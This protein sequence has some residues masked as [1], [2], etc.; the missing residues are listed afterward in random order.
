VSGL[1]ARYI[2]R[3]ENFGPRAGSQALKIVLVVEAFNS[4]GGAIELVD[5]LSAHLAGRGHRVLIAST[6]AA[7]DNERPVPAGVECVYL[8]IRGRKPLSW[9]H[10]ERLWREPRLPRRSELAALIAR[11]QPDLVSGHTCHWDT[12]PTLASICRATRVPWVHNLYDWRDQGRRAF[13]NLPALKSAAGLIAIS[14]ASKDAFSSRFAPAA[15]AEVIIGGVDENTATPYPAPRPYLFCA[16]RMDLRNK[17]LDTLIAAFNQVAQG[18]DS[19]DLLIAGSGP[20]REEVA[21]MAAASPRAERIR[22]LGRVSREQLLALHAGARLFV[23]PSR[24]AEGL[25]IV[26]LE[27][28]M[29]G[30]AVIGTRTGGV[31]EIISDGDNGR[32]VAEDD[33]SALAG[34]IE[35]LL[36]D[37]AG[38]RAMGERG[39]ERARQYTWARL[40][41]RHE[42]IYQACLRRRQ[43]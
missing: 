11:W 34:A 38:T 41:Q 15:G 31:E 40:A 16:A 29:A 25:G 22:M 24:K 36:A 8:P 42:E 13:A 9:R 21:A 43:P 5:H 10:L 37:A 39:R 23:M 32:L 4:I 1:D 26:F 19:L 28:M 2:Q 20:D 3:R 30:K 17:A 12:F 27:A 35:Q 7:G 18:A 6:R 33:P 14:R